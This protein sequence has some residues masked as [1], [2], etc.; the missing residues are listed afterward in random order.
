MVDTGVFLQ[1]K[2]LSSNTFGLTN[3]TQ[4][5]AAGNS[6]L[7][8]GCATG[9]FNI[10]RPRKDPFPLS[11]RLFYGGQAINGTDIQAMPLN[12]VIPAND[13]FVTVNVIP[14]MDG[15]P[16]GIETIKIYA[17]AGCAAGTPTDSTFIQVR[18]YDILNLTPDTARVCHGNSIQLIASS[19]YT[20]Y[21]WNADPTLSSTNIPSPLATPINPTTSYIC[22]AT[23]GTC[24]AQDS[25]YVEVK[26]PPS[27]QKRMCFAG[28]APTEVY[29][30]RQ[31]VDGCLQFSTRWME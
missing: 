3:L 26:K 1:A 17:L 12:V 14:L 13:S 19:G 24:Q 27:F 10:T 9:A 7:V 31:V 28:A 20:V 23:V 29:R 25:V 4:T 2:S 15:I 8:E 5:D 6:Y 18:D 16:E 22:T 11:I 21:Q 30:Y